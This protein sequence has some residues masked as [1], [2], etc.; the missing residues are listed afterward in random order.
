MKNNMKNEATDLIVVQ[1]EETSKAFRCA[2]CAMAAT[3]GD[4]PR[5]GWDGWCHE[6]GGYTDDDKWACS[7]YYSH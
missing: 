6:F 1:Q 5:H 7:Y 2:N 3:C 4:C